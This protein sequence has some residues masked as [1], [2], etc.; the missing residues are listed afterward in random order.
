MEMR[1]P[2]ESLR[3]PAVGL[4]CSGMSG[5]YGPADEA[6]SVATINAALDAGTTLLDSER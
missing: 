6:E 5:G 3:V 1:R 4:G 2:G